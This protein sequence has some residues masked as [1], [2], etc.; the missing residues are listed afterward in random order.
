MSNRIEMAM[1]TIV[2][3]TPPHDI[4]AEQ[5]VLASIILDQTAIAKV[6]QLLKADAFYRPGHRLIFA[7]C[8][9]RYSRGAVVDMLTLRDELGANLDAAGGFGY[10]VDL[11]GSVPT[12]M[13]AE[14]YAAIVERKA[15]LRTLIQI[16]SEMV[17]RAFSDDNG[18]EDPGV[19]ALGRLTA[20][21]GSRGA[22]VQ[23]ANAVAEEVIAEARTA[24]QT[25]AMYAKPVDSNIKTGIC[26]LDS[27]VYIAAQDMV[28]IGARPS[29][30]KTAFGLQLLREAAHVG[31]VYLASLEMGRK[32]I[33][34]RMMAQLT[35]VSSYAMRTGDVTEDELEAMAEAAYGLAPHPIYIDDR[36]GLTVPQIFA[37]A[38]LQ[39]ARVGLALVM[40]DHMSLV[41]STNTKGNANDKMTEVSMGLKA[42]GRDL[43]VPVIALAQLGRDVE[44][45][46]RKP[47]KDDLRDSGSVEQDADIIMLIHRPER[48]KAFTNAEI[49]VDK[50]RDGE[51]G[52]VALSFD[53]K[54]TLFSAA[55][56]TW[57]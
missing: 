53:G 54:R 44:K 32:A 22:S 34:R 51:C 46:G 35:G 6:V 30:G 48:D 33:V 42:I 13:H 28:V 8:V 47:R 15:A 56:G 19:I 31:P 21:Q 55:R 37:A 18:T 38:Q 39:Q 27:M 11:V 29:A 17:G 9:A 52:T 49:I 23:E 4:D 14:H 20:L 16:G 45:T 24:A 26:T 40:V 7:A 43:G 10:L 50:Q 5:A 12:T 1:P 57:G 36:S 25:R 41:R 2:E 3:R